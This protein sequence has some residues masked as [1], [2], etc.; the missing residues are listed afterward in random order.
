MK[1]RER[2]RV[3]SGENLDTE[4]LGRQRGRGRGPFRAFSSPRTHP[5]IC[6]KASARGN[7]GGGGIVWYRSSGRQPPRSSA[8]VEEPQRAAARWYR[9]WYDDDDY[10][11]CAN[12]CLPAG[13]VLSPSL[14]FGIPSAMV[15]IS[16]L[17]DEEV[18]SG[19]DRK[20]EPHSSFGHDPREKNGGVTGQTFPNH[21]FAEEGR[22]AKRTC[23]AL[24]LTHLLPGW[25]FLE[26]DVVEDAGRE[27]ASVGLRPAP[28]EED[29][30]N[31]LRPGTDT[32]PPMA[33]EETVEPADEPVDM[34]ELLRCRK[35]AP[36]SSAVAAA[37][38]SASNSNDNG[39]E[40]A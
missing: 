36:P 3:A 35:P 28:E 26:E 19:D 32:P 30:P 25:L 24:G 16:C 4:S 29:P 21:D 14:I 38:M 11:S 8:L 27:D 6:P 22:G 15:V 17:V 31:R 1:M 34:A 37:A 23:N 5:R 10:P 18:M 33:T 12:S 20:G 40:E 2:E 13:G 39:K 7:G 9:R